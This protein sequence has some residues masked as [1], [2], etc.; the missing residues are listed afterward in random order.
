MKISTDCMVLL[1][2]TLKDEAQQILDSSEQLGP[3]EYV[4]GYNLLIPGLERAL[5]GREVGEAFSLTIPPQDG[6]GER[7]KE[8]IRQIPRSQFPSNIELTVGMEFESHHGPFTITAIQDDMVTI[9]TNHQLAGETLYFDIKIVEVRTA[10][11]EEIAAALQPVTGCG[12]GGGSC[13]SGEGTGGCG[14]CS[15]CH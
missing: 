3:L 9:D 6:Y 15:G 1:E 11:E 4:H 5:E 10:S 12:C 8:A 14:G 2:Y 13:G 7:R